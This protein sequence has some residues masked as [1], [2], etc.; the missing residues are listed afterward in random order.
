MAAPGDFVSTPKITEYVAMGA[1]GGC[2]PLLIISGDA[3]RLGATLYHSNLAPLPPDP[4]ATR[5][6][7]QRS[8]VPRSPIP[9]LARRTLPYVRWIDWCSI[10]YIVS[11][12]VAKTNMARV[13]KRLEQVH[14]PNLAGLS[15]L[16]G[17]D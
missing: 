8:S 7:S 4:T 3:W 2:L 6:H 10:A 13:L 1:A 16:V 9:T 12:G 17:V 15:A 14:D 11:E 5:S